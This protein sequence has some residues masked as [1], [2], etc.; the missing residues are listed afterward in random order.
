V[1][2]QW[3]NRIVGYGNEAP[4]QLLANPKN[5]RRHPK[6]QQ[7]ALSG[8][9]NEVGVV[10]NVIV[11]KR[12]GNVVDGHLRIELAMRE[13]QKEIPVTYVDLSE[14]EEAE[15]LATLDPISSLAFTDKEKLD[16][17]LRDVRS[18][19]ENV[20]NLLKSLV[21]GMP[22]SKEIGEVSGR[23]VT[24]K[25]LRCIISTDDVELFETAM[26][27]TGEMNRGLALKKIC[28]GY[29]AKR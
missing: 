26:L 22:D 21:E 2:A 14:S 29:I 15:I 7:E 8:V 12:T 20:T 6:H 5:F 4:D 27:E 11:N 13:N 23:G 9:L 18:S 17:L 28:E 24:D 19:D 16:E 25:F 10:Q 1:I 3:Q